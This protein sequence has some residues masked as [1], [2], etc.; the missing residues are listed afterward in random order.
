MLVDPSQPEDD[1]KNRT[2]DRRLAVGG[3]FNVSP[4]IEKFL[5]D[6]A[7]KKLG[8]QIPKQLQGNL[9]KFIDTLDNEDFRKLLEAAVGDLVGQRRIVVWDK[10]VDFQESDAAKKDEI[11]CAVAREM[12]IFPFDFKN[13]NNGPMGFVEFE[14]RRRGGSTAG[15][16]PPSPG[17]SRGS[18]SRR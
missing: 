1:P 13:F 8:E 5:K 2:N 15:R 12:S 3:I 17:I 14:M 18:T 7:A 10:D 9:E 16:Q 6:A 4:G 11:A